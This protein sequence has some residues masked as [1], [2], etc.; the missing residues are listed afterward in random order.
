MRRA[1][2]IGEHAVLA[3]PIEHGVGADD[4]GVDCSRQQE[5]SD[6]NDVALE[7][8]AQ[9]Q[10]SGQVHGDAADEVVEVL[11]PDVVGHQGVGEERD[12]GGEDQRV[13][14]DHHARAHEVLVF[15]VLQLAVDLRKRFLAG[16]GQ[17]RVAKGNQQANQAQEH[18]GIGS[19]PIVRRQLLPARCGRVAGRRHW[20]CAQRS[21]RELGHPA[22]GI[23]V[24]REVLRDGRGRQA[25][26]FGVRED[27]E[28]SP[29]Q[30]DDDHRC[31]HVHDPEGVVRRLVDALDVAS[32]EVGRDRDRDAGGQEVDRVLVGVPGMAEVRQRLRQ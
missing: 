16:H 17:N 12:K 14:K 22:D 29:H 23:L 24:E 19:E 9:G 2:P 20:L 30:H 11:R 4:G 7:D 31:G 27:R 25:L 18:A 32:P 13:D 26:L 1:E 5:E 6:Q 15:R 21:G 8:Q 28:A 3:D 10:R